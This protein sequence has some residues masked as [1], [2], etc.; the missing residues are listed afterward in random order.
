MHHD[1][2][3]ERFGVNERARAPCRHHACGRFVRTRAS[4]RRGTR[5]WHHSVDDLIPGLS[6]ERIRA[7]GSALYADRCLEELVVRL[8]LFAP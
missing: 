7:L 5:T 4:P 8:L 2:A 1:V 6:V 3:V